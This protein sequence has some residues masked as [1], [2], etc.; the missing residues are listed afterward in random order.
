MWIAGAPAP[1]GSTRP[2]RDRRPL[3]CRTCSWGSFTEGD[4]FAVQVGVG[5]VGALSHKLGL[6]DL[7]E[8][9]PRVIRA[10]S[11]AHGHRVY[12]AVRVRWLLVNLGRRSPIGIR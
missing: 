3:Q 2:P 11:D 8:S 1:G 12:R 9:Q 6:Q 5:D 7:L 10:E 4:E